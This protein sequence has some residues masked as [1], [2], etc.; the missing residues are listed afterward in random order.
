MSQ[1]TS[2]IGGVAVTLGSEPPWIQHIPAKADS[3]A[4]AVIHLGT[5]LHLHVK[6]TPPE[7]LR[8]LAATFTELTQWQ[9]EQ[10]ADGEVA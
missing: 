7:A 4:V 1:T 5:G 2:I 8:S 6:H 9:E 3:R 10:L